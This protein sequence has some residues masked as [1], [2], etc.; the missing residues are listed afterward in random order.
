MRLTLQDTLVTFVP[1]RN[2]LSLA[3]N[4]LSLPVSPDATRQALQH[5]CEARQVG[6]DLTP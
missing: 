3:H 5:L 1:L 6:H 4:V 2:T